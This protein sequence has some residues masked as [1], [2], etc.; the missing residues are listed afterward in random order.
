MDENLHNPLDKLFRDSIEPLSEKPGK[1]VWE[2][3]E[4][5]LDKNNA[6]RYKRKYILFK[7]IAVILLFLLLSFATFNLFN[8]KTKNETIKSSSVTGK[9][10]VSDILESNDSAVSKNNK[11]TNTQISSFNLSSIF[12]QKRKKNLLKERLVI[13]IKTRAAE[14]DMEENKNGL[15]PEPLNFTRLIY[16]AIKVNEDG[17]NNFSLQMI[18]QLRTR[19]IDRVSANFNR[20]TKNADKQNKLSQ[21]FDVTAFAAPELAN[22]I[23]DDDQTNTYENRQVIQKREQH[24]FSYTAGLLV[25]YN[26][27]AKLRLQS[28]VTW[29]SSNINID[30]EK[31]YAVKDNSGNVKFRYTISSGYGYILP[32][33]S[34][35]PSIGDSLS[36]TTSIHNLQFISIPVIAQYKFGHKKFSLDPGVGIVF[37]FLTKATLKTEVN[38][39]TNSE[40]EILTKL[41]GLKEFNY[42]FLLSS[43][44]QYQISRSWSVIATPYFKFALNPINKGNV[45]E[46]YPYNIGLGMGIM[47]KL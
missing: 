24:L 12:N 26:L 14:Q 34:L 5:Q 16:G 17:N 44:L 1:H 40:N 28:G 39:D 47:R 21:H 29:S 45:V 22:Y 37:N 25:G 4:Q 30:P 7:R 15:L 36:T 35:S 43:E 2:G 20:L 6:E 8:N 10:T 19:I 46:T 42:S 11:G 9:E 31:I 33:F 41:N 3:V 23:L 13:R 27:S 38:D 18:Q 32:S